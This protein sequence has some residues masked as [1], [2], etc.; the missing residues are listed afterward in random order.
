MAKSEE[1]ISK[2]AALM[3][4]S[5]YVHSGTKK[6]YKQ[7]SF[8]WKLLYLVQLLSLESSGFSYWFSGHR[9]KV[10]LQ[11]LVLYVVPQYLIP[12]AW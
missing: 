1:Y 10:K 2:F 7:D 12:F 11:I 5:S 9:V 4:T 8:I 6:T 3:M